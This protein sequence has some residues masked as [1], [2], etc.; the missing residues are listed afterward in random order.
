MSSGPALATLGSYY[1]ITQIV[2]AGLLNQALNIQSADVI[3]GN[4]I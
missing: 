4:L 3:G 1:T 2:N